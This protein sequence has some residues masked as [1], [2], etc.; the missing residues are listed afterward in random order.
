MIQVKETVWLTLAQIR[1]LLETG[2]LV[3]VLSN[4]RAE[5]TLYIA[6]CDRVAAKRLTGGALHGTSAQGAS[7]IS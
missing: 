6:E 3:N 4:D 1:E 5:V 2:M 7:R